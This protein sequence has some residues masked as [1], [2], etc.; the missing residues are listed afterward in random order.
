MVG[1]ATTSKTHTALKIET[2]YSNGVVHTT[3]ASKAV[4]AAKKLVD[5]EKREA[6]IKEVQQE[7]KNI[8]ENYS[9]IDRKLVTIEEARE[10]SLKLD[11]N[12]DIVETPNFTGIKKFL[13][14]PIKELRKYIDWTFFFIAW[15][16]GMIYPKIMEDPKY[17]EE[18]KKLYKDA[19][20]ML[21]I[22]E[23]EN[24]L[25]ANAVFGIFPANSV[26][27]NIELYSG[28]KAETFNMLRQ[29][30]VSKKNVYRCL[31]DYVAPKESGIKDYIGGFIATAG[32][33]AAEY[34]NRL[35]EKGD[36]YG[37]AM[38][39]ILADRLA[40]A[41][42]EYLHMEVR[43]NYW[44]YSP[45]ENIEISKVLKGDYMGIRPAFG[46]PSLRDH[47]E[48]TKLFDILDPERELG[49]N[50]TDSY[51]MNPVASTCGLY[52]GNKEAKYFD[53]NKI[54]KDQV[55]DYAKRNNK[56]YR[57]IER[58]LNTILIYK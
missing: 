28:D 12:K 37:A 15:D 4:E 6:Y 18:A 45:H 5:P 39:K 1:G 49:I 2:Q 44:G 36:E 31:S 9:K 8:R 29:Q 13:N 3:D 41:F 24:I 10:K 47:A 33:G 46:Y 42:S 11:W 17:G 19:N 34:A 20:D 14:F 35:K 23:R 21:D 54:G 27:D 26:G 53:I 57:E 58:V 32:I 40:E 38:V 51:M 16:M 22:L 52:F 55:D 56:E 50:L 7:Y 30:E 43:K 25:T 48:K